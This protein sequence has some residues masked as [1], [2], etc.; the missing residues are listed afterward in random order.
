MDLTGSGASISRRGWL[1]NG[2]P[3]GDLSTALR[4]AARTRRGD[5]CKAPAMQNGRCRMHGG[6]STGPRTAARLNNSRR[7]RWKHGHYSAET[8]AMQTLAQK[9]IE[10]AFQL[11]GRMKT[12]GI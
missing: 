10:D 3:P 5:A 8:V 6:A 2:N 9:L 4:C 11:V 7:A 1:R 12:S